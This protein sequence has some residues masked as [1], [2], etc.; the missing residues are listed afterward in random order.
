MTQVN[1]GK[2]VEYKTLETALL[3]AAE[4]MGWKAKIKDEFNKEY[5]LG[6]VQEVQNYNTTQVFLSGRLFPAMRVRVNKN[7]SINNFY[8][9][10]GFPFGIASEKKIKEYL[11]AV[12]DNLKDK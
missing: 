9:L 11:S 1:M 2:T 3:N 7:F 6:S 12:S 5:K 8:V 10:S 4:K